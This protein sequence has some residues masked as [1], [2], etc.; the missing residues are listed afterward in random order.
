[1]NWWKTSAESPDMNSI[2][3]LLYVNW[4]VKPRT[5]DELV[6]GMSKFWG[7]VTVEKCN[8]YINHLKKVIPRV[9]ELNGE[10]TGYLI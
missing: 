6:D 4:E 2:E 10:P 5:K 7:T 9:V 8:Q 1:M 3:N